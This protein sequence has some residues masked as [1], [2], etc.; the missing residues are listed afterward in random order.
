MQLQQKQKKI[1][2]VVDNCAAHLHLDFLKNIQL[3]FVF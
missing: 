3:E 1:L 2:Q